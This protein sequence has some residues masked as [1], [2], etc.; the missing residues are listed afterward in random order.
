MPSLT[1]CTV[2]ALDQQASSQAAPCHRPGWPGPQR[3]LPHAPCLPPLPSTLPL[4]GAGGAMRCPEM[5][6]RCLLLLDASTHPPSFP[7]S[8]P[9]LLWRRRPGE[10]QL[11]AGAGCGHP[12]GGGQGGCAP[13]D[14]AGLPRQR[15]QPRG[16]RHQPVV[17]LPPG[18]VRRACRSAPPLLPFPPSPCTS[19]SPA[20][21]HPGGPLAA[22]TGS[23]HSFLLAPVTQHPHPT[24]QVLP[25]IAR[26]PWLCHA[27]P[28]W[29]LALLALRSC[30]ISAD[31]LRII[32]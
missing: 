21:L 7:A 29:T 25:S 27:L 6:L 11:P 30:Y 13:R 24:A 10:A 1:F 31:V 8:L 32:C 20:T 9:S 26:G 17:D 5:H 16:R 4:S 3:D 12:E 2:P 22:A 14:W 19:I 18:P 23:R 28:G 15:V